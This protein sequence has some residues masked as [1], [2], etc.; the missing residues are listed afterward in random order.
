MPGVSYLS[1]EILDYLG[2][3]SGGADTAYGIG[4]QE[5]ARALGYHPCSM[6]RPLTSLVETGHLLARRGPVRGGFRKHL[7]YSLTNQG[8]QKLQEETRASPILSAEIPA[9]PNPFVGR[10]DELRDLRSFSLEGGAVIGVEGPAGMGK[11]AL[12]ARYLRK[13][14]PGRV[15]FWFTIRSATAPRHL[16][17]TLSHCLS[18][19][20]APQLAYFTQI[21]RQP[22]G[23][24]VASLVAR[25]L[26]ERSLVAVFDDT[27]S[28]GP[29][30]SRFLEDF[31]LALLPGRQDICFL[32]GQSLPTFQ[33]LNVA[34]HHLLVGGLDRQAAHALTDRRGGLS[35][36]FERVYQSCLGSP[37]LLQL[38]AAN[39]ESEEDPGRLPSAVLDRLPAPETDDLRVLALANEAL[40]IRW[41]EE[42][43][44]LTAARVKQLVRMGLL[45][46][47]QE[48]RVE[49]LQIVRTAIAA[50]TTSDQEREGHARLADFYARSRRPEAVRERFLHLVACDD[51]R[52]AGRIL[53]EQDRTLLSLGYSEPLRSALRHLTLVTPHGGGRVRALRAEADALRLHSEFAE[54]ILSLH[55]AIAEA[56]EDHRAEAECM[57]RIVDLHLRMHQVDEADRVLEQARR[58]GTPTRR[59]QILLLLND[60]RLVEAKGNLPQAQV[61]FLQSFQLAKR[62]RIPDLAMECILAWSRVAT[63]GGELQAVLSVVQEA[64]PEARQY[65]RLDIVFNLIQV[66]ARVHT[67][68]GD[69]AQAERDLGLLKSESENLGYINQLAYAL[70]GLSALAAI[71][72][73][74]VDAGNWAR[75]AANLAEKLGIDVILGHTLGIL[76]AAHGRQALAQKDDATKS[77]QLRLAKEYGERSVTILGR[78]TPSDSLLLSHGYLAEVLVELDDTESARDHYETAIKLADSM[79]LPKWR[80]RFEEDLQRRLPVPTPAI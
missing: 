68:L 80:A 7:V 16:V 24:E 9:P 40:P 38:A 23:R 70:S 61:L 17:V 22:S 65:G 59:L 53:A 10:R 12:V 15:P 72:E 8:R 32:V 49:P 55:R 64:I 30:V 21:P 69:V 67:E 60:A 47:T 48:G 11:T 74:W 35:D 56:G 34:Q 54:A 52:A 76:C 1:A 50:K 44:S 4:Q 78:I 14:R 19:I 42:A 45:Q 79:G 43:G 39:P 63:L 46:E 51:H 36:R 75:Q 71:S 58:L 31:L 33:S 6:S 62:N 18:T 77:R 5:L 3:H 41:L 37:L 27:Q 29:D 13:L 28:L 57:F 25:G 26:G 20:G 2:T 66:S 73:R